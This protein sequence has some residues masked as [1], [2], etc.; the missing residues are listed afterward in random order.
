M[1]NK[2]FIF[3]KNW[4]IWT[5]SAF[6]LIFLMS[7][8]FYPHIIEKEILAGVLKTIAG[9]GLFLLAVLTTSESIKRKKNEKP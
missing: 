6:T 5:A 4:W 8:L 2:Y 9:T 1:A 7:L 3:I